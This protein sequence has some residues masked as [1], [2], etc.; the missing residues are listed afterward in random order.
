MAAQNPLSFLTFDKLKVKPPITTNSTKTFDPETIAGDAQS[1]HIVVHHRFPALVEAFLEHKR[2]HGSQHEKDLYAT[3][4]TFTWQQEVSRLIEKRSLVFLGSMDHSMLR[5][6]TVIS[7]SP[8][9]EWSRNGTDQ[10]HL[11]RY[12][13]LDEYLSYDEIMLSSLISVSGP[14]FFINNGNRYNKGIPGVKG[15]FEE[16][17]IIIGLVGARFE[18]EDVMDSVHILST[19]DKPL[20]DTRLSKIFQDFF[21]VEKI[22]N[23]R[24]DVGM[25]KARM[26]ITIDIL[27]LEANTRAAEGGNTAYTYVVGLGLGVWQYTAEQP[28]YYIEAFTD[29]LKELSIPHIS[30]LEFAWISVPQTTM[31]SVEVAA[32]K[33][34]IKVVFSRRNPAEKL[35]TDE[36]LV[37]SYAWDGNAFPGNEYWYVLSRI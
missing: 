1:T 7:G 35:W 17:G 2:S 4:E 34:D 23:S 19:K 6:G 18:R 12:L 15:T 10:Q 32:A 33:Q 5:D 21:G 22:S 25:Y 13:T 30:T 14:S 16:R 31:E 26:R 24:F 27:L 36:L 3:P 28:E 11:N 37:L 29:A 20:Q 8:A 9:Q